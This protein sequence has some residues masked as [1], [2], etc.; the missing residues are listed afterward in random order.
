MLLGFPILVGQLGNIVTGF[1]DNIMVGHYSTE[2]LAAASFVNN[3]FNT[4]ILGC[5][6]FTYGLTP[7]VGALFA[8]GNSLRI[9]GLTRLA[10]RINLVFTLL[11]MAVM[12]A[13]YFNL[14]H[15]GLPPEL[16]PTVRPYFLLVLAGMI[17][18]TVFNVMLQWSYAIGNTALPMWITLGGNVLNIAG[19]YLLIFG[20]G[21][22]DAMGLTGAGISTLFSRLVCPA[23]ILGVF[24]LARRNAGYNR[25][26]REAAPRTGDSR[27]VWRTSCPV[28][29][30][31]MFETGAFSGAAVLVGWLGAVPLAAYQIIVVVGML[32]F[33]VYYSIGSAIAVKV[34]QASATGPEPWR[35][36]RHMAWAGYHI[37]LVFMVVASLVFWFFGADIMSIFT[38]D[39]AV[40]ALA[41]S[42]IFPLVLYQLGDA[43]QVTFANALRGTAHVMPMLAIAF[44]SY[45]A[46]GLPSTY[47]LC[48]TA[49]LGLW[50]VV[51]S[52]SVSLFLAAALFLFFFLRATR[53]TVL[54]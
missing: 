44:V 25:G 11:I 2:A 48:F 53:R 20:H 18:V 49:G 47:L 36:M 1:A 41:S 21:G 27:L 51:L 38:D 33:C 28:A 16:L 5:V 3:L 15:M 39:A 45:I 50:G 29:L 46:V 34:S 54:N 17:P 12:T 4:A 22:F 6:G 7:L 52:F 32:G 35:G 9:G 40:L 42:L 30:Q 13:V 10:M 37:M 24:F 23:I 14:H 19:N 26:W 8:E 43:T 31:M